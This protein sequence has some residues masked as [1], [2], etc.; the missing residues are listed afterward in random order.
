MPFGDRTGPMGLGPMTG[1]GAGYCAGFPMPGSMNPLPGRGFWGRGGGRGWRHWYYATG[2]PGWARA[3]M[4]LPA[5]GMPM[6]PF[7]G[8]IVP[9]MSSEQ[10]AEILKGQAE[11]FQGALEEIKKRIADLEAKQKEK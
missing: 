2:L 4:G 6:H 11:C 7:A 5:W 10:E 3:G 8:P 1:R 9:P